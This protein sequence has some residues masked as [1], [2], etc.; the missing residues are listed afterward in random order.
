MADPQP[1]PP[2]KHLVVINGDPPSPAKYATQEQW[3]PPNTACSAALPPNALGRL[4]R[5]FGMI[6]RHPRTLPFLGLSSFTRR[7]PLNAKTIPR[8][9]TN[10]MSTAFLTLDNPLISFVVSFY[11]ISG[12]KGAEGTLATSTLSR[13]YSTWPGWP[14]SRSAWPPRKLL[15]LI[16]PT[17]TRTLRL[18]SKKLLEMSGFI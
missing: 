5:G 12:P 15:E 11:T 3:N 14:P 7:R 10:T 18:G 2:R 1:R 4:S 13:E 16:A 6:G 8:D 17:K 9:S